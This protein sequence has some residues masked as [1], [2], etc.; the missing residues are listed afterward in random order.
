MNKSE[1]N[2]HFC[3]D[4]LPPGRSVCCGSEECVRAQLY[5]KA[6]LQEHRAQ[7][8]DIRKCRLCRTKPIPGKPFCADHQFVKVPCRTPGC[9]G[10]VERQAQ[11]GRPKTLCPECE[12]PRRHSF[13][14]SAGGA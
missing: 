13:N 12:R 10:K 7:I 4:L 1:T 2:C 3:S 9:K 5:M 8:K 14:D 6:A 11:A